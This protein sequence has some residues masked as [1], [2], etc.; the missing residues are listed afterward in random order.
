MLEIPESEL[1]EEFI[2][3]AAGPGGQH[4]NRTSNSVRLFFRFQTSSLLTESARL[5]LVTLVPSKIVQDELVIV[6]RESRS[7]QM[8]RTAARERL[9]QLLI[10]I[11]KEPRKR[12]PTKA[13]RASKEERLQKKIRRGQIK[14]MRSG[15]IH[16]DD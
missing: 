5:R 6:A 11:L 16:P 2:R 13:T 10:S 4:V 14:T 8:N 1:R 3:P 7:L 9:R 15:K 12:R